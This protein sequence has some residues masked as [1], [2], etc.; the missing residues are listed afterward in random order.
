MYH[1]IPTDT[2]NRIVGIRQIRLVPHDVQPVIPVRSERRG[3]L[4]AGCFEGGADARLIKSARFA[5]PAGWVD[6]YAETP[7]WL[8]GCAR[9]GGCV[10]EFHRA[11]HPGCRGRDIIERDTSLSLDEFERRKWTREELLQIRSL[12][13]RSSIFEVLQPGF[14]FLATWWR[15]EEAEEE[16]AAVRVCDEGAV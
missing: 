7:E 15:R 4:A 6:Q 5:G 10:C 2:N 3:E 12:A 1:P 8:D 13:G 16:R 11:I 14:H 9:D